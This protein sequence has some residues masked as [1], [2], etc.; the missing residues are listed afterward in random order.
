MENGFKI[1]KNDNRL[2]RFTPEKLKNVKITTFSSIKFGLFKLF[3][4]L[5]SIETN[6]K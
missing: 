6:K 3:A 4:Y 1:M 2:A 5:C